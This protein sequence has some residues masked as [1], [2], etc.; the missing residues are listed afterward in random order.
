MRYLHSEDLRGQR[1]RAEMRG[2]QEQWRG[3]T[4]RALAL[5]LSL[6][7]V[8]IGP[9]ALLALYDAVL[10]RTDVMQATLGVLPDTWTD[11]AQP[12]WMRL[13]DAVLVA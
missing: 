2:K 12:W 8:A 4:R 10:T 7:A 1:E 9:V 13:L 3:S 6:A 5:L 11:R